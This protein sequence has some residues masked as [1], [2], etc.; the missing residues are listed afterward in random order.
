MTPFGP[1]ESSACRGDRYASAS[2]SGAWPRPIRLSPSWMACDPP[3][4]PSGRIR[5]RR[6]RGTAAAAAAVDPPM[7]I[8][9]GWPTVPCG[10]E[11]AAPMRVPHAPQKAKPDLDGLTAIRA[12]ELAPGAGPPV[13][14]EGAGVVTGWMPPPV[15]AGHG[16]RSGQRVGRQLKRYR[17]RHLGRVIPGNAALRLG[18]PRRVTELARADRGRHRGRHSAERRGRQHRPR[19]FERSVAS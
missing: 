7:N 17:G 12:R 10:P 5:M 1:I 2:N 19:G 6:P 4:E 14:L 8:V 13:G 15:D 16:R 18:S 3:S 11:A 9:R